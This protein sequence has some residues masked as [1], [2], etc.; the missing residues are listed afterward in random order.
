MSLKQRKECFGNRGHNASI[1]IGRLVKGHIYWVLTN[2]LSNPQMGR[3]LRACLREKDIYNHMM[4]QGA[5][6]PKHIWSSAPFQTKRK[7]ISHLTHALH[8]HPPV[9]HP[10]HVTLPSPS[11]QQPPEISMAYF[12]PILVNRTV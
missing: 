8:T 5:E 10:H 9:P 11:F 6:G 3:M 7:K 2:E 1:V 12:S 4:A